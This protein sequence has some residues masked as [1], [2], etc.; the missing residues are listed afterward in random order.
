MTFAMS[1]FRNVC[2]VLSVGHLLSHLA[3]AQPATPHRAVTDAGGGNAPGISGFELFRDGVYWWKS[4]GQNNEITQREGTMAVHA[5]LGIR[6][7]LVALG[8]ASRYL[9]Q[10]YGFG[11]DGVVRDDLFIYYAAN[12]HLRKKPLASSFS[13]ALADS[14]RILVD[15]TTGFPPR[16]ELVPVA[17]N[18][19][20][21]LWRGNL[22]GSYASG[23]E[24]FIERPSGL[25][26]LRTF[27]GVGG[28]VKRMAAV[29]V[30][31]NSGS[32]LKDSLLVLTQDRLLYQ[33]DLDPF[34]STPVL[35]ARNVWDF[36][37]RDESTTGGGGGIFATRNHTT[38]I[39]AAV[40]DLGSARVSGR[41]LRISARDRS[42]SVDYDTRSTELQIRGVAATAD[43][44]YVTV[45]PLRCGGVFG[46]SYDGA[47]AQILSRLAPA[48]S[49][50]VDTAGGLSRPGLRDQHATPPG[51][52]SLPAAGDRHRR[53]QRR[54]GRILLLQAAPTCPGRRV[55]RRPE[56]CPTSFRRSTRRDRC[57][58]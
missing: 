57:G 49:D 38:A 51:R 25:A 11:V 16:F 14:T 30:L 29:E 45:T 46:C 9:G 13:D 39:Y 8:P 37:V 20:V 27:S 21:L 4:G 19:A 3:L 47:N 18:G 24:F 2:V 36:A 12:G 53:L 41:L 40:G 43:R 52:G 54:P 44:L 32:R 58:L 56:R 28:A 6:P 35:L 31:Q 17:A 5:A 34:N 55:E 10:G 26:S 48:H 22:W 50:L 1:H 15:R 23:G 7:P 42:V 33:V